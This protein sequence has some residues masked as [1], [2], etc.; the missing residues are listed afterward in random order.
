MSEENVSPNVAP[1]VDQTIECAHCGIVGGPAPDCT[2]CK[3]NKTYVQERHFTLTEE[4]KGENPHK[5]D[6]YGRHGEVGPKIVVL[7]GG[8]MPGSALPR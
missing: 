2:L 7:P 8:A 5:G 6:R 1:E 3:G 4:R